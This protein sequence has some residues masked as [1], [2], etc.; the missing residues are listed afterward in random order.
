MGKE[1]DLRVWH[2]PQVPM[3][4]FYVEVKSIEEAIKILNVLAN[5][6]DFEFINKVKPDY[7]NVQGLERWENG[8]WIEWED[9]NYNSI[10]EVIDEAE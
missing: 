3:K 7:S 8:G 5:Y 9:E 4:A 10:L 6:D 2:I 1:G